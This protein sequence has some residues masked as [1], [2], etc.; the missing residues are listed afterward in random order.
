MA[1]GTVRRSDRHILPLLRASCLTW[2][3]IKIR[4]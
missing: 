3:T 1:V 4:K 2:L